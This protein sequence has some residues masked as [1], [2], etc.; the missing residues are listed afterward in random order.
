MSVCIQKEAQ[1]KNAERLVY[2][3]LRKPENPKYV[4]HFPKIAD[5]TV[6]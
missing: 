5:V 3:S 4:T 1:A 6:S 2:I